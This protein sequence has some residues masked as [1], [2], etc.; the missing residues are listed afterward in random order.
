LPHA[1]G[2]ICQLALVANGMMIEL[3]ESGISADLMQEVLKG[4]QIDDHL[5]V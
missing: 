1:R 4:S 2:D 5:T 3:S